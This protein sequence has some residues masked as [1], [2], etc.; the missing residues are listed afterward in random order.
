MVRDNI[1]ILVL[2][3]G[4]H[5]IG[6]KLDMM[7]N[8]DISIDRPVSIMPD[9]NPQNQGRLLFIPYLQ[10]TELE[11]CWFPNH[12]IRHCLGDVKEDLRN[13]YAKQFGD[14]LD[15]PSQKILLS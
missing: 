12:T 1:V 13:S 10:F 7:E 3:S 15:V 11:Q 2:T 9:P 4:E 5:V 14:G 6:E 8:G